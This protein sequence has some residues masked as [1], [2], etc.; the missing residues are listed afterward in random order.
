M[1]DAEHQAAIERLRA[2]HKRLSDRI[3]AMY[4]DKLDGR[5]DTVFFDRMSGEWR[6]DQN[7]CL[8][9]IEHHE[10]AEQ[11]YMEEGCADSRTRPECTKSLRTAATS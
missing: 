6:E 5:V 4:V 9:E 2:E 10:A 11:S 3:N 8:R 1:R 7:R